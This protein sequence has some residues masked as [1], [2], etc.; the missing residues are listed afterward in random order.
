MRK[1]LASAIVAVALVGSLL[2]VTPATAGGPV[3]QSAN[4]GYHWT[5]SEDDIFGI[6]VGNRLT[7]TARKF[8]DGSVGG[9]FVY[10]QAAFG[11]NFRFTVR[12]TCFNV[13]DGNRAKVGSVVEISNDETL[14]PGVFAWFQAIDNGQG[15]GAAP[16][17]STLVGFGD[18]GQNQAFCDSPATP[19]FG[20]WDVTGNLQ[21]NP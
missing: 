8:S 16:D 19:R 9:V 20:P 15:E 13:Y 6:E 2:P 12:V 1:Q 5:V 21:V 17:R 18:A 4:G 10:D 14:P 3:V 11:D 7:V